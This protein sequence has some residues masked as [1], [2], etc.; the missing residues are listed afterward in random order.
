[1]TSEFLYDIAFSFLAADE[2]VATEINDLLQGR[3]KTFLYSQRQKELAG[4]DGE[5]TFSAVLL[6][7]AR[8][9][10]VLYRPGWGETPWT[11]I[12]ET[13]IRNRAHEHGYDFSTFIAMTE[14][15]QAPPWLPKTRILL[16]LNR[17]GV[18]GAGAALD[19]RIQAQGGQGADEGVRER[20]ERLKRSQQLAANRDHF[21]RSEEGVRAARAAHARLVEDLKKQATELQSLGIKFQA[22]DISDYTTFA[23]SIVV[24]VI[25]FEYH[26]GNSLDNAKLHA[27]FFKGFP[28]LPGIMTFEDAPVI[29]RNKFTFELVGPDRAAWVD[30]DKREY[31]IGAMANFLAKRLMDHEERQRE[32]QRP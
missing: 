30:R 8:I 29:E 7:Q 26:Y 24:L 15:V 25:R 32:K 27:D 3:Y 18:A 20:A 6:T 13:A 22:R 16:G 9:V 21:H 2:S 12:E 14:P 5:L 23:G 1:M 28:R 19:A 10:A 17:F 4:T 11:R 31:S